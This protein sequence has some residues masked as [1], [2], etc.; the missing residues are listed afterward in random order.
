MLAC[1]ILQ[2]FTVKKNIASATHVYYM[3]PA[4]LIKK[5]KKKKKKSLAYTYIFFCG[6]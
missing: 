2:T 6:V 1:R 4:I 3:Q 5:K